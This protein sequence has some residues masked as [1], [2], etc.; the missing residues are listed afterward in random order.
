MTV[1]DVGT[2]QPRSFCHGSP[3]DVY[4]VAFSPDGATLASCGRGPVRLWDV[5]TGRLLLEF[6]DRDFVL[7]LEFSPDGRRLAIGSVSIFTSGV[8]SIWE[9]EGGRGIQTLRGLTGQIAQAA[10]SPDGR[11]VAALSHD[12]QV[13]IWDVATTRLRHVLEVPQGLVADNAALAFSPDG[14]QFAF[15]SGVEAKLWDVDSGRPRGTWPLPPGLN[16]TLAFPSGKLLLFRTETRDAQSPPD[17]RTNPEEHP[18]VCRVRDL[19]GPDPLAPLVE[20]T[21]YNWYA[22]DL[23]APSDGSYFI[24]EGLSGPGGKRRSMTVYEGL[25]G[26]PLMVIPSGR[27][28]VSSVSSVLDLD[29]KGILLSV[30]QSV[31]DERCDLFEMPSGKRLGAS[32]EAIRCLGPGGMLWAGFGPTEHM[33]TRG[34]YSIHQGK[35]QLVVLGIDSSSG[36]HEPYFSPDGRHFAWCTADGT[37][38]VSD[39]QEIRRRLKT[40]GLGW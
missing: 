14:R 28:P 18:R 22:Y 38:F 4:D 9:L 15:S 32:E 34:G 12:W 23:L 17:S 16:D 30:S 19:L 40:I 25:T 7:D 36:N 21:D 27:R 13:G 24:A 3:F 1:W 10:F 29:P 6:N 33:G 20:I 35:D 2:R 8:V 26:K 37:V 39:L 5:A 31:D 11:L